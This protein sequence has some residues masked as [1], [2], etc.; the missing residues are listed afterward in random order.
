MTTET[1]ITQ[2]DYQVMPPLTDEEYAALESDIAERGV[3][4]PVVRDQHGNLLDGHHRVEIATKL[5][6]HY[7][8]DTVEVGDDEDAR[9]RARCYNLARRHLSRQQKRQLIADEVNADP[10]R[11]DR[12]IGR[13]LGVDHKT[14]GSVRRELGGEIPQPSADPARVPSEHDL[15]QCLIDIIIARYDQSETARQ[16]RIWALPLYLRDDIIQWSTSDVPNL[17][18]FTKIAA[19]LYA[20]D[21]DDEVWEVMAPWLLALAECSLAECA[22][23]RAARNAGDDWRLPGERLA[24]LTIALWSDDIPTDVRPAVYRSLEGPLAAAVVETDQRW[25]IPTRDTVISGA[26]RVIAHLAQAEPLSGA[27]Q[28]ERTP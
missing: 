16:E 18:S 24:E 22:D 27:G 14:V 5:G 3:L 26:A 20:H 10:T 17:V 12:A 19:V 6:L 8:T 21:A 9:R 28:P 25:P 11:S 2:P 23:V 1:A 15:A 4:V 13:L 7:R